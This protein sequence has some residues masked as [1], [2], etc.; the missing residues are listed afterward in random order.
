[1]FEYAVKAL[2][3][4]I[5]EIKYDIRLSPDPRDKRTI[6]AM[7]KH[8]EDCKQAIQILKENEK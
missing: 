1:M 3:N 5:M 4:E 7:K 8:I 6:T 2:K